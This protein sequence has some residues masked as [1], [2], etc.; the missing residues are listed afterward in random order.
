MNDY[1]NIKKEVRE[2]FANTAYAN[3]EIERIKEKVCNLEEAVAQI[4]AFVSRHLR[5]TD[6]E[7]FDIDGI[8]DW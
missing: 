8:M 7:M 5:L 2:Q 6:A 3:G 4:T 1:K